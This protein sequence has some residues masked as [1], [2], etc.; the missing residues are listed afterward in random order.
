MA[1]QSSSN[2]SS[3]GAAL[4]IP[5]RPADAKTG[6]Q[7][8]AEFQSLSQA[9]RDS[10]VLGELLLGNVPDFLRNLA[11]VTA[12][13]LVDGVSHT[14][15]YSVLPDYLALGSDADYLRMPMTPLTAQTAADAFGAT[16]PTTLM[17]DQIYA[18]ATAKVQAWGFDPANGAFNVFV[19]SN[20]KINQQLQAIEAPLG[21]PVGGDKKDVV[22]T[23]QLP[24]NPN[25]VAIYGFQNL[26]DGKPIQPLFLG[27]DIT[28]MDYSHGIR[29]VAKAAVL[30][31]A[32]VSILDVLADSSLCALI[33]REGPVTAPRYVGPAT[34]PNPP[35]PGDGQ[36]GTD[37]TGGDGS[38][39]TG[40]GS[41]STAGGRLTAVAAGTL[42]LD[43]SLE[44]GNEATKLFASGYRFAIRNVNLPTMAST[45]ALTASEAK[46]ILDA[47]MG[48]G[49]YQTFRI[50]GVT[51]AQGTAD[52][53]FIAS[54]AAAIG[55][56]KGS[57]LYCDLESSS[58]FHG[59]FFAPDGSPVSV[60]TMLT[61]LSNWAAAVQAQ[62]YLA[63]LY[64]GP[65]ALLSSADL[66]SLK[67]FSAFWKSTS[68][69]PAPTLGYQLG[70][71]N[72]NKVVDGVNIDEDVAEAD[73]AGNLPVFWFA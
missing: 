36:T 72:P 63:G 62:G 48:L 61:Y 6:S 50:H 39:G 11:Q 71:R 46:Q 16:L 38:P 58:D 54:Q 53:Q 8:A 73:A 37:T 13:S 3:D 32:P 18:R 40:S 29:M 22:T 4:Q 33:S 60:Q 45:G 19:E 1:L 21:A 65:Q 17:V 20:D 31:G 10:R 14:V 7:L 66:S 2:V 28:Y 59:Q 12:T 41:A 57:L 25:H 67:Q 43:R 70:Q 23:V 51:E 56:P 9:A 34:A 24:Q 5:P 15:V 42:G 26:S 49:L 68:S 47:G 44:V 35:P 69:V 52:G 64:N 55:F 27:H 30:D